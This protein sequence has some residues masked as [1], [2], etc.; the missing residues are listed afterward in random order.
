MR[1]TIIA[2]VLL[3]PWV[4]MGQTNQP[5]PD[6][7]GT[8][9]GLTLFP[10]F[11]IYQEFYLKQIDRNSY[12][13]IIAFSIRAKD[14]TTSFDNPRLY[15]AKKMI[16]GYFDGKDFI[17]DE[18]DTVMSPPTAKDNLGSDRTLHFAVIKDTMRLWLVSDNRDVLSN[19]N[20]LSASIPQEY[21]RRLITRD[22][23]K[24]DGLVFGDSGADKPIVPGQPATDTLY[25][26]YHFRNTAGSRIKRINIDL[27]LLPTPGNP[28]PVGPFGP[29]LNQYQIDLSTRDT[30]VTAGIVIGPGFPTSGDSLLFRLSANCMG[31][32]FDAKTLMLPT[33]R[34]TAMASYRAFARQ[35]VGCWRPGYPSGETP[36]G[37]V[38][39]NH[40]IELFDNGIGI[41][42]NDSGN[43]AE[44]V[45]FLSWKVLGDTMY[46]VIAGG[47]PFRMRFQVSG[48]NLS[49]SGPGGSCSFTRISSDP[50][51]RYQHD[52]PVDQMYNEWGVQLR[53]DNW[54]LSGLKDDK[55]KEFYDMY[56]SRRGW[57]EI[58]YY[59]AKD[60]IDTYQFL[61]FH[62][63]GDGY[64][65]KGLNVDAGFSTNF[66][67][68]GGVLIDVDQVEGLPDRVLVLTKTGHP[69]ASDLTTL[70]RRFGSGLPEAGTHWSICTAC[71]GKGHIT[72]TVNN[73]VG[74]HN[75]FISHEETCGICGGKGGA[76]V[77]D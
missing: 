76:Y 72:V 4:S 43:T 42:R 17:Y 68:A 77:N 52:L 28:V 8:W 62:Q 69:P 32:D 23:L 48:D 47:K 26:G 54:Q 49:L 63:S 16:L 15:H 39:H 30:D 51:S 75:T 3:A 12:S 37:P 55:P 46:L 60:N 22:K 56:P 21:E 24:L 73:I 2:L 66:F 71:Q 57:G 13:G 67:Y 18:E 44:N 65:V 70:H 9:K 34:L 11:V 5:L 41:S 36:L 50:F 74:E 20:R 6:L 59:S 1:P 31:I 10:T 45:R 58:V 61:K 7:S 53:L 29:Y 25:V 14:D 64:D 33:R 40:L 19:S 38:L 35:L 27:G